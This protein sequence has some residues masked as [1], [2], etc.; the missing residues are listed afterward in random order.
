[1]NIFLFLCLFFMLGV[2]CGIKITAIKIVYIL[3]CFVFMF[4]LKCAIFR[5]KTRENLYT[6]ALFVIFSV[7]VLLGFFHTNAS[8]SPVEPL[9]GKRVTVTGTVGEIKN[10]GFL[11]DTGDY[12]FTVYPQNSEMS[13]EVNDKVAVT[14]TVSCYPS[15]RFSGDTDQRLYYAVRGIYGKISAEKIETIGTDGKFSLQK[16]GAKARSFVALKVIECS[17]YKNTGFVTALLTGDTSELDDET[18]ETF[19]LTGI[20]HLIAVSGLHL[21]IFMSFF[22]ILTSGFDKRRFL[23]LISLAAITFLYVLIVGARSSVLRAGIMFVA[24]AV[25]TSLRKRSDSLTNL[26]ISGT[27][28]CLANPF[29]MADAGFQMSFLATLGIVLFAER[30]KHKTIAV[31][32]ITALFMIPIT[33]YYYNLVSLSSVLVN[34]IIVSFVPFIILFGYIG[35]F[36]FPFASLSNVFAVFVLKTAA[37]FSAAKWSAVSLPSTDI[38]GIAVWVFA[39]VAAYFIIRKADFSCALC[40]VLFGIFIISVSLC[41][42]VEKIPYTKLNF[43]NMGNF[44]M[45]HISDRQNRNVLIDCGYGAADYAAKNGI[46]E[47]SAV[48]ITENSKVKYQGLE[49]LCKSAKV[50]KVLLPKTMQ[51]KGLCTAGSEIEYYTVGNYSAYMGTTKF[52]S[53]K[54]DTENCFLISANDKVV[55][56]PLDAKPISKYRKC[57]IISLP[58]GFK[59]CAKYAENN[60]AYYY[61]QPT[62]KG[63]D[64]DSSAKYI[65]AKSGMVGFKIYQNKTPVVYTE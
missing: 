11:L 65:T 47:I 59:D 35:C 18:K 63:E 43:I 42:N 10:N 50:Q 44:N 61:I 33:V 57:D 12:A 40:T 64:F 62:F 29:Y 37:V 32:V 38:Y 4:A 26:I 28:L 27:I 21:G 7:G 34:I 55:V 58:D 30:F 51:E 31:P 39:V 20:S 25:V 45:I 24:A 2:L 54:S 9:Y 8:F 41:Q 52:K 48:I 60:G 17:R 49:Q 15:S 13:A 56:V 6:A 53:Y 3:A 16:A 5:V 14:G 36:F 19:R 1:M 46:D 23:K 22:G